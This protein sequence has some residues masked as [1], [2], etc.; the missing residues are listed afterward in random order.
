MRDS[1]EEELEILTGKIIRGDITPL[2]YSLIKDSI[3]LDDFVKEYGD[4]L[5]EE[6][7]ENVNKQRENK[8]TNKDSDRGFDF[9]KWLSE[10]SKPISL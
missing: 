2:M 7:K 10:S 1:I 4:Y 5:T 6:N 8:H 3:F 9:E